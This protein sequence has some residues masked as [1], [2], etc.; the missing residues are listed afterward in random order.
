MSG[1]STVWLPAKGD[2]NFPITP[3]S[4]DGMAIGQS[5][6]AAA[7]VSVLTVQGNVT[8][9]GID[10]KSVNPTVSVTATTD[11]FAAAV[12]LTAGI[13]V[14][15]TAAFTSGSPV[16]LPSV[17]NWVGGVYT[18]FNST[19]HTVAVWPQ[20]GD[21]IDVLGTT[22]PDLLNAGLRANYY[23]IAAPNGTTSLG[24]IFSGQIGTTGV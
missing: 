20:P 3:T 19:T 6:P 9:G 17:A 10:L 7:T 4:I 21:Q 12:A 11:T 18:V 8:V 15:V 2:V 24:Q 1:T 23:G 5:V 16:A 14:V 13:N 22:V